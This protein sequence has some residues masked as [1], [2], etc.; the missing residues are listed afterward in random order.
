MK[1]KKSGEEAS[2]KKASVF[3]I[4]LFKVI[5][6]QNRLAERN[7]SRSPHRTYKSITKHRFNNAEDSF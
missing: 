2:T 7:P 1:R 4:L 6:I 3:V 5:E